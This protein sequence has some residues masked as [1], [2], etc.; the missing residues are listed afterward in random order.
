MWRRLNWSN[1]LRLESYNRREI[2]SVT[3]IPVINQRGRKL[4]LWSL[5][6]AYVVRSRP[7]LRSRCT[8]DTE[9]W[10][11]GLDR[12]EFAERSRRPAGV[13]SA[14]LA[15]VR[16]RQDCPQSGGQ[17]SLRQNYFKERERE[18]ERQRA[19]GRDSNRSGWATRFV[20]F[21]G[22]RRQPALNSV[23]SR[24]RDSVLWSNCS[25]DDLTAWRCG[26]RGTWTCRA[27]PLP[28]F[29]P[30]STY[31]MGCYNESNSGLST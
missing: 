15:G 27:C 6:C 16:F 29:V 1:L 22:R 7:A 12:P 28:V 11:A 25:L 19:L 30:C 21:A 4:T 31:V 23:R 5:P 24:T 14:R 10:T 26:Q 20:T 9:Q 17:C 18:R 8:S 3:K 13:V 2:F